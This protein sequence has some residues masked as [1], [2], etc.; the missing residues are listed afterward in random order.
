MFCI[1]GYLSTYT[2]LIAGQWSIV[3][4]E[5]LVRS[6]GEINVLLI[7]VVKEQ[8][9][10][11]VIVKGKKNWNIELDIRNIFQIM[12]YKETIVAGA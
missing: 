5:V 12:K 9:T 10:R 2:V 4:S 3:I 6:E 11:F 7:G 8:E 1:C